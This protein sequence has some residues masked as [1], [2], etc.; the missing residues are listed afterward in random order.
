MKIGYLIYEAND[1]QTNKT[2]IEMLTQ[3]AKQ[4]DIELLLKNPKEIESCPMP[5]FVWNRTRKSEISAYYEHKNIRV[6]NNEL[7]N[8]VA[9]HKGF[10]I[11]FVRALDINSVPLIELTEPFSYP[12]VIKTVNGHGGQEVLLCHSDEELE[13]AMQQFAALDWI[14]QPF[15]ESNAQ[16]VRIWMIGEN[17]IGAVM[18]KG[19]GSFKSNYSLGGTIE[20]IEVPKQLAESAQ[21][22]AK[23][24]QS[25]YIGIDFILST[26]GAF[27]FNELE[28]PVGAR[29]YFDLFGNNLPT[30]LIQHID[31]EIKKA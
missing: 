27:Y 24:L 12:V 21:L 25:D 7:S 6:F 1:A 14:V 19:N 17:I 3:E 16:D 29:S 18:R 22:I 13:Q 28:D 31:K 11:E 2:F 4:Y 10:A 20:K 15:I 5:D 8:K 9:N 30:L 23:E 26:E